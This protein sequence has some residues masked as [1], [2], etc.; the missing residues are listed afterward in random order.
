[1]GQPITGNWAWAPD[2]HAAT[3]LARSSSR[4]PLAA[5]ELI[6]GRIRY[7]DDLGTA[8]AQATVSVA[9][10]T[11]DQ[12]GVMHRVGTI[13]RVFAPIVRADGLLLTLARASGD[14]HSSEA[15]LLNE[16]RDS[17]LVE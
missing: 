12:S 2:E 3:F 4:V 11:W 8:S 7:A 17:R 15:A 1:V 13:E 9:P 5:L 16:G 10:A 6:D 14:G